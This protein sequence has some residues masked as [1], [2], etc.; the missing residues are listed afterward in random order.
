MIADAEDLRSESF[1]QI[2]TVIDRDGELILDRWERCVVAEQPNTSREHHASLRDHLPEL[3]RGL[4]ATLAAAGDA[5]GHDHRQPAARHGRERWE[6]GWSLD[7]VVRDYQILRRVLLEYLDSVLGRPLTLRENLAVG[8]ALD[9]AIADSVDRYVRHREGDVRR[10]E[11]AE[12][13]QLRQHAAELAAADRHKDDFLAVVGHE[14]RN[15]LAPI[16][17]AVQLLRQKPDA[18]TATWAGEMMDRQ[19]RH[20]TRL[21]DDLL[22]TSRMARGKLALRQGRTDLAGLVRATVGD[23]RRLFEAAGR[24]MTLEAPAEPVLIRGDA[25]RLAQ[26]LDNLLDNAHKFTDRGGRI[27]VRLTRDLDE[28]RAVL[29]IADSGVGIAPDLLPT[30]F[31]RY[32]QAQVDPEREN[33]GLGL[34][35]ALV[36]G[37]VELHGGTVSAASDGPGAGSTFTVALPLFDEGESVATSQAKVLVIEDNRDSADSLAVLL[38]LFG[39]DARVAYSGADGLTAAKADSPDVILCDLGL[40]GLDGYAVAAALRADPTTA[41]A[42]LVAVSGH[43]TEAERARCAEAGF[44]RHVLKPVEPEEVRALLAELTRPG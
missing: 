4:G 10:Q 2:G 8:L 15:P 9:E 34:G 42:R 37:L 11:Q 21:V 28:G 31:Q 26:V 16:R 38:R 18:E 24:D 22:D 23:R 30:V 36:K 32:R 20:L 29:T 33:G 19:L 35:L 13:D 43:G 7:E 17:N 3:L 44:V 5:N 39:Y 40:P 1:E 6:D 41:G 25:D 14:L 27:T 12:A